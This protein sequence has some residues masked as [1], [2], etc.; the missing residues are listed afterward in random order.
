ML[1]KIS[2]IVSIKITGKT[3]LQ[4]IQKFSERGARFLKK[5]ILS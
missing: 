5:G 2:V 1:V 4:I 3:F